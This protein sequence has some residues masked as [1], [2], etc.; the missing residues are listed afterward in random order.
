MSL[1][2]DIPE[3]KE[4]LPSLKTGQG[5]LAWMASVDHK[6]LGI[7]YLWLA[8]VFFVI[9]GLEAMM[10][11]AQLALPNND[12]ISPELYNQIFTMHGTTM[13]FLVLM[14]A[15]IGLGTYLI[16]LMIG[17][18][19]M[20]FPRLNAFSFWMTCL[21]GMLLYFSF[22][23]G[24]APDAGWFNYAPLSENNYS[25]TQ[26][27]D[28]FL[29]GLILTGIGSIGAAL[30]FITTVLTLR[31]PDIKL[32]M[33]PLFVWMI[34][35]NAFLMLAAFPL[36]NA[37]LFMM[38]IDRQFDAHFFLASTGGSAILWQ[39]FFW[40]F[41][42]PEVYIIALP[43][44]GIISEVIPVF[45][46][47]PI[48][49]YKFVAASSIAIALLSYSVWAHHM[50][51]VGLSNTVNAFFAISSMLIGIPTG[52]KI[53]N[54][55]GTMHK[56]SIRLTTPMLWAMAFL[57]CFTFGGLTGISF[58]IVPITWQLTDT[59]YLV[60]HFHYVF[61]GGSLFGLFAGIY[62]W[63][64]KMSGR[65]LCSKL[66]KWHFWLFVLGFNLTFFLQHVLG[67]LGMPRR[68][69]TYPDLPYWK[70]LN[71]LATLGAVM[72]FVG[73]AIFFWN[74]Y[75]TLKKPR[76]VGENPWDAWTLEW[77]TPSPPELKNFDEIPRVHSRRPL[78]D[79]NNPDNPDKKLN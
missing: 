36:L 41:G 2:I 1:Y 48:Y 21:G 69:F 28:Y 6:Q 27:V 23:A 29:V 35:V 40:A 65:M 61:L 25:S 4:Q 5:K 30:N 71:M 31:S 79:I 62:Y 17:A 60:A 54:W 46:R 76:T 78:W 58:A 51:T 10:I 50:F 66:G 42:H 38:L 52:L 24:G 9:G 49:G 18:N 77:A 7:M 8:L 14:P 32:N 59:Y 33:L 15:S 11:R 64:P 68:I 53:I 73:M 45:S 56:G 44:F 47:K 70:V 20:A 39:H 13:I 37:G 34:F 26:G 16:P 19:E 3:D 72:M 57:I 43:A 63:F 55:I 22:F 75:K 12:L 74:I 67:V